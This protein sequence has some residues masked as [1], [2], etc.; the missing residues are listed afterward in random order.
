MKKEYMLYIKNAGDPKVSLNDDKLEEF[1]KRREAYVGLLQFEGKLIN[2]QPLLRE[3]ITLSKTND[4]WITI[5]IDPAM[6][7]QMG[8]Y[9]IFAQDM[10]EAIAV[11]KRSPEFEY[12]PTAVIEIRPVR[13][14]EPLSD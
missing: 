1:Y 13:M 12:L 14:R 3:G 5:P 7:V 6:E 4:E 8:Y 2:A 9:H 10:D 11:A